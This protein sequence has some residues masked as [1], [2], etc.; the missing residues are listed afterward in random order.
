[1]SDH[2]DTL[3]A[4]PCGATVRLFTGSRTSS[5]LLGAR[6]AASAL[7]LLV[8]GGTPCRV[9]GPWRGLILDLIM[10]CP[11]CWRAVGGVNAYMMYDRRLASSSTNKFRNNF[12]EVCVIMLLR[13]F[14]ANTIR[15]VTNDNI[16]L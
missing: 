11:V 15:N 1:M 5:A 3:G 16:K 6:A 7:V 13:N 8:Q 9:E 2:W 4:C 10:M 14:R 12:H